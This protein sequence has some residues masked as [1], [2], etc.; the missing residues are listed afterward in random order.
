MTCYCLLSP[1][2]QGLKLLQRALQPD[3]THCPHLSGN[4]WPVDAVAEGSVT[5]C[6]LHLHG[7]MPLPRAWGSGATCRH[8]IL[9]P[10]P[11]KH[12]Q[13][14]YLHTSYQ[15]DNSLH[16]LKKK[17]SIQT[18]SSPHV[19]KREA[20]TSYPGPLPYIKS[21]PRLQ[22]NDSQLKEQNSP[23]GSN[24]ETDFFN[25]TDTSKTR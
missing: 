12:T 7:S 6:C 5:G 13:A 9:P 20:C 21:P 4:M 23:E 10:P 2:L 19:R 17:T 15:G 3:A 1:P 18:K 14:V 25:L 8:C 24:N 22:Q 11:W 16:T